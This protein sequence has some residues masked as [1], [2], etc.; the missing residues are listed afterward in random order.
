MSKNQEI[1]NL[2]KIAK[3]SWYAKG[4]NA[5]TIRYSFEVFK[6][7]FILSGSLLELG[8]AEGVM[9]QELSKIFQDFTVVEGSPVFCEKLRDNFPQMKVIESLFENFNPNRTFDN[10]VLGHILEHVENPVE[11]LKLARTWLSENGKILAAVPN[12]NSIH[13]QAAVS[14]G[15]LSDV[16]QLNETDI[17]HGHRRVY[18]FESFKKDFLESG[19]KIVCQGGYWLKPLSNKQIEET[20]S[21]EM[22]EAFMKLGEKYPEIAAET[23]I[24]AQK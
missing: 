24:I 19:L 22:L 15:L 14:M 20:W 4:A 10:I 13:R 23:Y 21:Q 7:H 16:Y 17:H 18:D 6:R 9:T 8:P 1:I 12:A 2:D 3:D 11:I 5:A